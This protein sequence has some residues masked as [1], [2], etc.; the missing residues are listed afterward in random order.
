MGQWVHPSA[1]RTRLCHTVFGPDLYLGSGGV[2]LF[3]AHL[4]ARTGDAV[5]RRTALAALWRSLDTAELVAPASRPS[6]YSGWTGLALAGV[7]VAE[8][9]G[10]EGLRAPSLELVRDVTS[11]PREEWDLLGGV[12]GA[13]PALLR[14]HDTH[15]GYRELGSDTLVVQAVELGDHLLEQ[16]VQSDEGLSW[17]PV[18]TGVSVN[19]DD[20][21]FGN[22]TGFSHG[23]GGVGWA[24]AELHASTGEDRFAEAAREAFRY[25]RHWYDAERK[26]WCDLRDPAVLGTGAE[27]PTC[28]RGWCHGAGGLALAR[29]RAWQILGDEQLRD[30]AEI[31]VETSRTALEAGPELSQNNYSLCH[32]RG[33][34]AE[35]LLYGAEVLGRPE[36]RLEAED[37]ALRGVEEV[38]AMKLP[39]PCGTQG[40]VEI[41]S[42]FVGLAG[43]GYFYLRLSDPEA[44]PS[45]MILPPRFGDPEAAS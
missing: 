45:V 7:T 30:E 40:H 42:L 29:L 38:H 34:N 26:N 3:L 12:A 11:L 5:F 23:A 22:L 37:A 17:G 36:W 19:R 28:M 10:E 44:T 16:A 6:L 39:W 35:S 15:E 24:L 20:G 32:G 33:G 41:P 21:P 31:A 1:G 43:I 25:E 13:I 14:L 2:A 8:A 27:E 9:L 18:A 4:A